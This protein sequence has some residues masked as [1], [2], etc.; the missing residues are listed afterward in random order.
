MGG[1]IPEYTI[2]LSP[3]YTL[4]ADSESAIPGK[5]PI[6]KLETDSHSVIGLKSMG[7]MPTNGQ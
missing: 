2:T 1:H 7:F 4:K 5:T 6:F 3:S